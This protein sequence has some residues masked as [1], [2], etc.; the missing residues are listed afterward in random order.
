[1]LLDLSPVPPPLV[2]DPQG[3][4]RVGKSRLTLDTV[5]VA[6]KNGASAEQIA[7]QFPPVALSDVYAVIAYYLRWQSR[8]EEYLNEGNKGVEAIQAEMES[9]YGTED[10]VRA[11]LLARSKRNR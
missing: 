8:V 7:K 4:V 5:V 1:M 2:V 3:S 11:R 10:E 6:F 9:R